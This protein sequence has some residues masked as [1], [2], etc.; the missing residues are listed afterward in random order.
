MGKSRIHKPSFCFYGFNY[1]DVKNIKTKEQVD[2][3]M[4]NVGGSIVR[5]QKENGK[6]KVVQNDPHNRRITAK[7][8]MK[9]NWDQPINGKTTVIGTLAYYLLKLLGILF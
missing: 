3:E 2:K 6:W 7:T 8:P 1:R 4:Y 9:L 5:I